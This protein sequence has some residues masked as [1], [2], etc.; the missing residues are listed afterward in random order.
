MARGVNKVIIYHMTLTI[1]FFIGCIN[2]A[3]LI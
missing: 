1:S 3:S 2:L